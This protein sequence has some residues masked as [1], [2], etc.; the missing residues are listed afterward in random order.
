M[1]ASNNHLFFYF[2][3]KNKNCFYYV[4]KLIESQDL[5]D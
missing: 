3:P 4:V 2:L 1:C 5:K